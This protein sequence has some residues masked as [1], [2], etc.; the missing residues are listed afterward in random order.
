MRDLYFCVFLDVDE[1]HEDDSPSSVMMAYWFTN[2]I[3]FKV[4]G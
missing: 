2:L 4:K 1:D 3:Q